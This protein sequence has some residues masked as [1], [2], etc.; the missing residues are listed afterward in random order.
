MLT[1]ASGGKKKS[2]S[3]MQLLW[4]C[5]MVDDFSTAKQKKTF[6]KKLQWRGLVHSVEASCVAFRLDW[7]ALELLQQLPKKGGVNI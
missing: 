6:G 7:Q 2:S 4:K 3:C 1:F 5:I